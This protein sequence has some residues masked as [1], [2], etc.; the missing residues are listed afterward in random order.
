M[1]GAPQVPLTD[2]RLQPEDLLAVEET[3]RS[4]WL[5]MGPK[6]E[7][8][9]AAFAEYLGCRYAVA[10]SSCTAALHLSYLSAGVGPGDEVIVPSFTF[11]ATASTVIACG[12]T[13]VFA[14]I[15]GPHDLSLDPDDVAARITPR[16]RAIAVVHFAGYPAAVDRLVALCEERGLALIEDSAHGPGGT[17]DGRHLGT[18]GMAGAFSLFS[19]KILSVGEG[20]LLTTD[21]EAVARNARSRRSHAMSS[22]TWARHSGSTDSYDVSDL[23]YN[24]RLDDM[25]SALALSLLRRVDT[26]V[27]RRRELVRRYRSLLGEIDGVLL[28]FTDEA[29]EHASGYVMPILV[30]DVNRRDSFQ[31]ALRERHG[32]QTSVFYPAVHEFTAYRARFPDLSLPRTEHAAR[33][34]VTIPLYPHMTHAEQDRVVAAIE[35]EI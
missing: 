22:G 31:R 17:L 5:T 11:A 3:L 6:T 13:P 14:D 35:A 4:G 30:E 19:N 21:D 24:Y 34:E 7:T 29:V 1:T 32:V 25:H 26:D 20:G 10:V 2:V 23:G 33:A 8:F 27:A 9:E 16:T 18:W 15:I 28:P 12:A